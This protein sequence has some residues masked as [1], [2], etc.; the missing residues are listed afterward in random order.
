MSSSKSIRVFAPATSANVNCGF[1]ILGFALESIGDE[2]ILNI[3]KKKGLSIKKI[4]GDGGTLPLDINLNS[5]TVAM[6]SL[7][8]HNHIECGIDIT[9]NKK[10]PSESGL[11]S[12]AASSVAA[13]YGLNALLG[14]NL[15]KLE[16]LK[17][18]IHGEFIASG[19]LH[20][21]NIAPSM[22]GGFTLIR[23]AHTFDIVQIPSPSNL[24]YAIIHPHLKINTKEARKILKNY[25]NLNDFITQSANLAGLI[26]GLCTD[27]Y[28]L[29]SR[30]LV[31]VVVEPNRR[32]LIP[33]FN[34]IKQSVLDAGALGFG[35]SGSGPSLF[36][37]NSSENIAHKV[38]GIMQNEFAKMKI[39]SEVYVGK[40]NHAG[41]L[42]IL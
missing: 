38:G 15:T 16:L 10:M 6:S 34:Y 25:V 40:I 8:K 22:L 24:H 5:A 36:T 41:A 14:L 33:N 18:A 11:G 39:K 27:D 1:D 12:S 21:D 42:V 17:Y 28:S 2:I 13:V 20:A 37:L 30:S 23:D 32:P 31:D 3:N 7:L 26:A 4:T 9:I 29:I 35:I 19:A